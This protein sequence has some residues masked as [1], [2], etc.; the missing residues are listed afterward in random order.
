MRVV[1][2]MFLICILLGLT[3]SCD[4]KSRKQEEEGTFVLSNQP[5]CRSKILPV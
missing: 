1:F 5:D 2:M 4:S 3:I